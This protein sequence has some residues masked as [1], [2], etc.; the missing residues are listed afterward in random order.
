MGDVPAV[1]LATSDQILGR[2]GAIPA[3]VQFLLCTNDLSQ[4]VANVHSMLV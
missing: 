2:C 4:I 3:V 1:A